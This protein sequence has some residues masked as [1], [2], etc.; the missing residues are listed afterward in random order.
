MPRFRN[1]VVAA[2]TVSLGIAAAQ[3]RLPTL[4]PSQYSAEQ[5]Q[6]ASEFEAARKVP[7]FG[8]FEPLLYSPQLMN[9]VRATG[10]YLRYKSAIGTTLSEL[11]ILVTA[12]EWTQDY[13]WYVHR[14]I[15][16]K[17]GIRPSVIDAIADGRRPRDMNQDEEI[18]YE[19][20]VELHRNKQVSDDTF[21]RAQ[22]RFG[23]QG[24]VDLTGICGYYGLLAMQL[25]VAQY[26][27]PKDGKPLA[28]FPK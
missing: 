3:D 25:N 24:V 14:P 19:F 13:E 15:A 12:R 18:V 21:A 27:M 1:L 5:K 10:D 11:A 8:P 16:I 26:R 28:R 17:A 6:A 7:I 2:G 23:A 20:A 9:Q 22:Q 4:S